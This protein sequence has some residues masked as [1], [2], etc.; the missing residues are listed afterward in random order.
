MLFGVIADVGGVAAMA[1]AMAGANAL[2]ITP[3]VAMMMKHRKA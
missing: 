2:L 3:A 1:I